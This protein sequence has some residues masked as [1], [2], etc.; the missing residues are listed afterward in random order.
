MHC[1]IDLVEVP[2]IERLV[3]KYGRR[4]TGRVFTPAE[5]VYCSSRRKQAPHWAARLAG[6]EAV[7]KALGTGLGRVAWTDI[8]IIKLPSGEPA[9][10]LYGE[11]RSRLEFLGGGEVKI[12]LSHTDNHAVAIALLE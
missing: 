3:E 6:K 8:E 2:R 11:A 7:A 10:N 5:Q 4:F 12:S 9:V 1:G